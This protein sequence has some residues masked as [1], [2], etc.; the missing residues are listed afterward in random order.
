MSIAKTKNAPTINKSTDSGSNTQGPGA[1]PELKWIKLTELYI[2]HAYQRNA[3]SKNSLKN[4]NYIQGNF[5]WAHCG[6]LIVC[7]VPEKK[8]YAVVDGQ[9]RYLAARARND[10]P[11]LPCVVVP[12]QDFKKQA[13]SFMV[14]N[15]KRVKL[16][17]LAAFHA[18]VTAGEPDAVSL[19][20]ILDDCN[21]SIP[22]QPLSGKKTAPRQAQCCNILLRMLS[23][24]SEK[25][26]K[27]V[28]TI[29]PEAYGETEGM[30][31]GSLIKA[32]AKYIK[33]HPDTERA[34][35]IDVLQQIDIEE[36]EKDARSYVGISGGNPTNALVEMLERLYKNAGRK[37]SA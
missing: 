18:S 32:L 34:R 22:T 28:L 23:T 3:K 26:I 10:I 12:G 13:K 31:R 25:Q 1:K 16:N 20:Q 14:V 35:M 2:D 21:I 4:L 15:Q 19:Q 5:C 11:E 27:W 30:M 29:I 33:L 36:A 9:H 8:Q 17:N 24:Y 7:H 37:S 6:A